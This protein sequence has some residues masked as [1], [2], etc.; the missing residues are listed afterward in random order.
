[1]ENFMKMLG[2]MKEVQEKALEIQKK[3]AQLQATGEAG[4]GAVKATVDGGKAVLK[5]DIDKEFINPEE[6][7]MLQDLIIAAINLANKAVEEKVKEEVKQITGGR[8][9][10]LPLELLL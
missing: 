6:K 2:Q 10:S 7:V 8:L 3:C 9:G 4:A 1:M 5:L